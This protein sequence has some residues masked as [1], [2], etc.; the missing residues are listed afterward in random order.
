MNTSVLPSSIR[1]GI[2]TIMDRLGSIIRS[3]TPS[4]SSVSRATWRNCWHAIRYVGE[5]MNGSDAGL[6]GG[7]ADITHLERERGAVWWHY[8]II[9]QTSA[10]R[11][12]RPEGRDQRAE[13]HRI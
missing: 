3:A 10:G 11:C 4:S 2:E 13:N 1:T 5:L 9:R 6:A 12:Q 8:G 7:I